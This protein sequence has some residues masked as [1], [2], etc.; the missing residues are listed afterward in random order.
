MYKILMFVYVLI[1]FIPYK[2]PMREAIISTFLIRKLNLH[3]VIH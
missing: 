3:K 2:N 1:S